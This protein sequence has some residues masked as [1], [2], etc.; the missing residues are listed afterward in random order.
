[1][2]IF[3]KSRSIEVIAEKA[4]AL[5]KIR[6]LM[7]KSSKTNN[8]LFEFKNENNCAIH[9][10]FVRFSF[11]AIWLDS[12][13]IVVDFAVVRPFR[14]HVQPKKKSRKL[15]EIPFNEGNKQIIAFF[16]GKGKI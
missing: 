5:G 15:I 6:G 10:F 1:M 12:K 4:S 16:V 13:N 11:L 9:S 8:L 7:F 14:F 2:K 3:Y